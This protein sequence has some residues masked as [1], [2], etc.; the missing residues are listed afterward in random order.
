MTVWNTLRILL[1]AS[2][3]FWVSG[4][5]AEVPEMS[6]QKMQDP[7]LLNPKTINCLLAVYAMR[8]PGIGE[9]TVAQI[10]PADKQFW[11][12]G[13]GGDM[14]VAWDVS[15]IDAGEYRPTFVV[16]CS[17][18]TEITVTGPNNSLVFRAPESGWQRCTSQDV[19]KLGVGVSRITLQVKKGSADLN[20]IDLVNVAEEEN[21]AQRIFAFRGDTSWMKD[22]G[23]GIMV[24][25]GGWCYPPQG[26]KKPWPG[27]AKD[28]NAKTFVDQ[29][30]EMGGKY[31]VWSGTWIDYL[32][33]AP[34][35]AIEEIMPQRISQHDLIADLIAQCRKRDIRFMLYYHL[36]HGNREVLLAKGWKD[37]KEQDFAA[38]TTW[39]DREAKIFTEIGRR[40]GTGLDAI[41]LDGG[42]TWYPADFEKLG[43]A[44]KKGNP[45]RV[46]CY[47]P[48][49]IPSL[50]PFQDFWCGEGFNGQT[51]PY[52]LADGVVVKGPQQGLQLFGNFMFD[53]P[54]WGIHRPNTVIAN[55]RWTTDQIVKMTRRLEKERYSVAINLLMYE[56]GSMNPENVAILKEAAKQLKRGKWAK[57]PS[58]R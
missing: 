47:N 31:L 17:E 3:G 13:F 53:G 32:F 7:V 4:L 55:T 9:M 37:A 39:L 15:T 54:D 23:Y 22:A 30:D 16:K 19:L 51:T 5:Q 27:F 29:V 25:G 24:Q 11:L 21:I 18:G 43:A 44:L 28:F 38:R 20:S 52:S 50:T 41:F 40:Y 12:Q 1:I 58:P 57:G 6:P 34:I 46:I 35:K 48:W 56:D 42:C 14:Q 33:P 2:C 45:K 49:I 10:Q 8:T 26:E 36:G